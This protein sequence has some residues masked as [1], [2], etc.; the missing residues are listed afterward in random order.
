MIPWHNRISSCATSD[1]I[2]SAPIAPRSR[3]IFLDFAD[4]NV[5]QRGV[6]NVDAINAGIIRHYADVPGRALWVYVKGKVPNEGKEMDPF[7]DLRTT[8][9]DGDSA[10]TCSQVPFV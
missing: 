5:L 9:N 6:N 2:T 1:E 8:K 10:Y 3:F 7:D 4:G